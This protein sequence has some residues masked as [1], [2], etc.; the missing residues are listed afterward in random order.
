MWQVWRRGQLHTGSW[1]GDLRESDRSDN[2]G[3]E[4]KIILKRFFKKR[5]GET[6]TGFIWLRIRKGVVLL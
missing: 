2:R 6:W 3:V 5:D 4:E 1:F